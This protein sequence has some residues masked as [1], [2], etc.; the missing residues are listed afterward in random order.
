MSAHCA[1]HKPLHTVLPCMLSDTFQAGSCKNSG[2]SRSPSSMASRSN[3]H[4]PSSNSSQGTGLCEARTIRGNIVPTGI[5]QGSSMGQ[6]VRWKA[7]QVRNPGMPSWWEQ[8]RSDKAGG[9]KS[10]AQFQVPRRLL[11][12][13]VEDKTNNDEASHQQPH[14]SDKH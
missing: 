5:R 11:S 12:Q 3:S 1:R 9:I 10:N 13:N 6:Q 14:T 2:S 4:R 8:P 7:G